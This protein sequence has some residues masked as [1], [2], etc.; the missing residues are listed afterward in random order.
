MSRERLAVLR[1]MAQELDDR[2]SELTR[3]MSLLESAFHNFPI[4]VAIWSTNEMGLCESRRVTDAPS[5]GWSIDTSVDDDSDHVTSL[6]RCQS[7]KEQ[8]GQKILEALGGRAQSFVCQG[9][10]ACI[11]T[12]IQPRKTARGV[13]GVTGISMDI[14]S[15]F[16]T[17]KDLQE[18][19]FH[20]GK[21]ASDVE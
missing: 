11:W 18:R 8:L 10:N 5:P 3:D 21:G 4:P 14:T 15:S 6:Y 7:L 9:D 19:Y 2:D 12:H 13:E 1:K 17:L 20:S 16:D